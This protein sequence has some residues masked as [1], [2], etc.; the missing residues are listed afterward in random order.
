MAWVQPNAYG[1]HSVQVIL[2]G[3]MLTSIYNQ[4]LPPVYFF[5][6]SG[7]TIFLIFTLVVAN[8]LCPNQK[9]FKLDVIFLIS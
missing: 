2:S 4:A 3:Q 5:P 7:I 6:V 1:L 8:C 9:S